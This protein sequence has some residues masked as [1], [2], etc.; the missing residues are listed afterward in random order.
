MSPN[1]VTSWSHKE[2]M[3]GFRDP[4]INVMI[5]FRR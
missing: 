3:F 5:E 2:M 4:K 1:M